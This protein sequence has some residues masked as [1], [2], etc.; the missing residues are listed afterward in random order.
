[1][2]RK[3]QRPHKLR[4]GMPPVSSFNETAHTKLLEFV[5][6]KSMYY[7][8]KNP[9]RDDGAFSVTDFRAIISYYDLE[10]FALFIT[11]VF[12]FQRVLMAQ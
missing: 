4:S 2:L 12:C 6:C 1:M 5:Y 7:K 8:K 10:T 3:F 11:I 9:I